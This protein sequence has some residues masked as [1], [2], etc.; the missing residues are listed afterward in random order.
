MLLVTH[1][2]ALAGRVTTTRWAIAHERVDVMPEA[3]A[4]S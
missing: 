1:D 3:P 2:D 4:T